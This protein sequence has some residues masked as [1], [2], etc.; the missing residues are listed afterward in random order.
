MHLITHSARLFCP[1]FSTVH[2]MQ[3]LSYH[4]ICTFYYNFLSMRTFLFLTVLPLLAFA[5]DAIM[6]TQPVNGTIWMTGTEIVIQ[7]QPSTS[8]PLSAN[9]ITIELMHGPP[10]TL[11]RIG[12]LGWAKA[13]AGSLITKL[14]TDLITSTNYSIRVHPNSY[15][16]QFTINNTAI[17]T[18]NPNTVKL[19]EIDVPK[20]PSTTESG[21]ARQASAYAASIVLLGLAA[22]I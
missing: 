16:D 18:G 7:W 10:N 9:P 2:L 17:Q 6:F 5:R 20:A 3:S 22:R 15:S 13:S 14:S 21:A 4:V 1:A 19:P 12:P 11:T 8:S